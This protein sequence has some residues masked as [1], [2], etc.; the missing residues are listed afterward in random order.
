MGS[1][2]IYFTVFMFGTFLLKQASLKKSSLSV[3]ALIG[4]AL[5]ILFAAG[6]Y[7][8]GTDMGTYTHMFERYLRSSWQSVLSESSDYL[9]LFVAKLTYMI[10][11]RVLTWGTFAA[12]TA[13]PTYFALSN[14]YPQASFGIAF[15]AFLCSYYSTSFNI[16]RQ[17]VSVALIFWGLKF[18]F[19]NQ[20]I[21]FILLIIIAAGFH[22]AAILAFP[23]WFLWDHKNSAPVKGQMRVVIL[24]VITVMVLFYQF[25]I[26]TVS[27]GIESFSR[28]SSYAIESNRGR[29]RDFYIYL[30]ELLLIISLRKRLT[31]LDERNDFMFSLLFISVLIGITGF[32]H[33][34]VKRLAYYY[35]MP[36]RMILAGY[37]PFCFSRRDNKVIKAMI[38]IWFSAIFVLTAYILREANLIP[39]HF[40]L[41]SQY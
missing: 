7:H 6:R 28:Y 29:N 39:Y 33:P 34:Q 35:A 27:I 3:A 30:I 20:P 32:S 25:F 19:R 15:F 9:F 41:F 23:M 8:V 38:Y 22:T 17:M 4:F 2:A 11:G 40:D 26:S 37:F 5:I 12:L 24:I 36:A 18:I 16:T 10:G 1:L 13:I 31:M 21:R 14:E